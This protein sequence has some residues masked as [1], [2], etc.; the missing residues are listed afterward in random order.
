M[1]IIQAIIMGIIQ[2]I[3]E[4]FPV[5][6][7][8]NLVAF[9]YLFNWDF[10]DNRTF[11]IA[12]HFGTLLAICIYFFKDWLELVLEGFKLKTKEGKINFKNYKERKLSKTGKMFWFLVIATIP[13]VIAGLLFDDLLEKIV[14]NGEYM[15]LILASTLTIMGILLFVIDKKSKNEVEYEKMTFKQSL[16]IGIS[17]AFA[18][19]PGFSR[20]GTTM[21]MARALKIDRASAAKFSFLLGTPI[22]AGAVVL[23]LEDMLALKSEQLIVFA[24]GII[25]SFIVGLICIKTLMTIIKKMGFGVFAIYRF[26]L[27]LALVVTYIIR[28]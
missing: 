9:K 13:G 7:S 4:F 24:V 18:I 15:P 25:T 17:Q 20:S 19:I 27:A 3:T 1:E 11:D 6:S 23:H 14:I 12:L 28:G 10:V 22:M 8:G 16:T 2:G 26:I 5:S 21:T